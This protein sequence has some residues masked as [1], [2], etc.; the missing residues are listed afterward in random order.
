M[1]HWE[2]LNALSQQARDNWTAFLGVW[3]TVVGGIIGSAGP[4]LLGLFWHPAG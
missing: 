4:F 3:M 1:L 2:G